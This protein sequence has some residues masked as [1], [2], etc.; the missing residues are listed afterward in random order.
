MTRWRGLDETAAKLWADGSKRRLTWP[1][2]LQRLDP[3]LGGLVVAVG[4]GLVS[5]GWGLAAV[6]RTRGFFDPPLVAPVPDPRILSDFRKADASFADAVMLGDDAFL[7][8][9]DGTIQR[10]DTETELFAGESLPRDGRLTGNLSLLSQGCGDALGAGLP[11]CPAGDT[12]FAVTDRGGLARRDGGGTW[13]VVLGDAGW[14]APDGTPV[15]QA[16][17]VAW[18][19]SED[20]RWML[21]AAGEKGLGLFDQ[22]GGGWATLSPTGDLARAP[23]RIVYAA[24]AFWLGGAAGL[25]RLVPSA[26]P[27]REAVAGGEGDIYDLDLDADGGLL[28]LRRG[29]CAE[30]CLSILSVSPRGVVSVLAGE[31]ALSPSLS[32][33]RVDHA[34]M[35]A[36]R[37]VVLG[38][39]GVHVYDPVRRN[40]QALETRPV[41][42][43]H[44]GKDGAVIHF[45]AANRMATVTNAT[46]REERVVSVPLT[47]ILPIT[48]GQVLGLNRDGA[49]LD[50]TPAVPVTLGFADPGLPT[51]VRFIAGADVAGTVVLLGP[52]G[53]LL[54][55]TVARRYA[56]Q[57]PVSLPPALIAARSIRLLAAGPRLWA[58][59]MASG[60][61]FLGVLDGDWPNRQV[62]F[63]PHVT[64]QSG[65]LSAQ[66]Q[67]DT[68]DL[69]TLSGAPFRIL[70]ANPDAAQP[71]TGAPL[72]RAIT[73]KTM[74][75]TG[76]DLIFADGSA[77]WTYDLAARGWEGPFDGPDGGVLDLALGQSLYALT[78]S[79]TLYKAG[80][81]SWEPV[82]GLGPGATLARRDVTDALAANGVVY[83]GGSGGV[84]AYAPD[85]RR[86][87]A[88]W[89][90]GRGDVRL[91]SVQGG[92]PVWLS[93][94]QLLFGEETIS[95]PEESVEGAWLGPDGP[96]YFAR[97]DGRLHAVDAGAGRT[98]LFRGSPAPGGDLIDA[99]NLPDG[100][101]FVLTSAAAAIYEPELRRWTRLSDEAGRADS[102]VEVMSGY[103]LRFDGDRFR[104][105]ALGDLPRQDSCAAGTLDVA[106]QTDISA[107][108]LAL[109]VAAGAVHVLMTN[110]EVLIWQAGVAQ[111]VLTPPNAA[112]ATA[113]LRRVYPGSNKVTFASNEALWQYDLTNRLWRSLP[114]RNGPS[115][116]ADVDILFGQDGAAATLW[117]TTGAGWG[118]DVSVDAATTGRADGLEFTRLSLPPMP[119]I[120]MPP[121]SLLDMAKNGS[122]LAV[123]GQQELALFD[124]DSMLSLG[125]IAL[126]Q[127]QQGWS[128]AQATGASQVVLVDGDLAAPLA[129]HMIDRQLVR[130]QIPLDEVSGRYAPGTDEDW[131]LTRDGGLWRIDADL[132]AYQCD[133]IGAIRCTV[134][135]PA[136]LEMTADSILA[137]ELADFAVNTEPA[138][139]PLGQQPEPVTGGYYLLQPDRLLSLDADFRLSK[140]VVGPAIRP[141]ARLFR[142]DTEVLLWEGPD[143][144]LWRIANRDAVLLL[145]RVLA[146]RTSDAGL[147]LTTPDGL[148]LRKG[149]VFEAPE[150]ALSVTLQDDVYSITAEGLIRDRRLTES[151]DPFLQF[152]VDTLAVHRGVLTINA[153]AQPGWWT[154]SVQG[155]VQF[156]WMSRCTP[157]LPPHMVGPGGIAIGDLN[158]DPREARESRSIIRLIETLTKPCQA[159]VPSTF[160][161][162]A[163]QRLLFVGGVPSAPVLATTTGEITLDANLAEVSRAPLRALLPDTQQALADLSDMKTRVAVMAGRSWLAP[164]VIEQRGIGRLQLTGPE[165][166]LVADGSA[167]LQP[168]DAFE[169]GWLGWDRATQRVRIGSGETAL[170][171]PPA[172]VIV[173]G[174]LLPAHVGR[175]AYLGN[176]HFAWLNEH[177]LWHVQ[178]GA[179]IEPVLM[180]T[181]PTVT[182]LAHGR[183]LLQGGGVDAVTGA[184]VADT[185]RFEAAVGPLT[186]S[187]RLR[188]GGVTAALVLAQQRV[189]A[190]AERGF[191]FDTRT[192]V[193]ASAGRAVLLTP[194]GLVPVSSL[195]GALPVPPG[196]DR[197][198]QEAAQLFAG[199]VG[200]WQVLA[201]D[202]TWQ[203]AA[204]PDSTRILAEESGRRWQRVVGRAEVV[205]IDVSDGW[206]VAGRGLDFAGDRLVAMAADTT[207]IVFVTGVGT[208]AAPGL[209]AAAP[210]TPALAP[211]PGV[212]TLDAL[213]TG[214]GPLVVWA[215]TASGRLEWDRAASRWIAPNPGRQPWESRMA[216]ISGPISISFAQGVAEATMQVTGLDGAL[217]DE[218][219][220]WARGEVLPFDRVR[221][222]HVE[223]GKLL[224]GTDFG[225]RRLTEASGLAS[226]DGLFAT[227]AGIP[228]PV[229]RVG[230]PDAAPAQ[231]LAQTANGGCLEMPTPDAILRTCADASGLA[232]RY[233][234]ESDFWRWTK[235]DGEVAGQY[236]LSDGSVLSVP[237]PLRGGL[238]HDRL[239]DRARCGGVEAELW[240]DGGVAT[241]LQGGIPV[242]LDTVAGL[243]AFHCQDIE[244]NLGQGQVLPTGLHG[245]GAN[246]VLAT[247]GGWQPEGAVQ[248]QSLLQRATGLLPWD[249][250]RLRIG[251]AGG[252]VV[253]EYRGLDDVWHPLDWAFGR[254]PV[255]TPLALS[256]A[257][258]GVQAFTSAGFVTLSRRSGFGAD[259][260]VL[261]LATPDDRNGF[262]NCLPDRVEMWDGSVQ[263]APELSAGTVGLRCADGRLFSGNPAGSVDR[264]AFAPMAE[265][266]FVER[267]V[268]DLPDFWTWTRKTAVPG[269]RGAL[270]IVFKEEQIGLNAGRLTIDDYIALAAPF[271]GFIE[272]VS[273]DGWWRQPDGDLDLQNAVRGPGNPGLV[274]GLASDRGP[275]NEGLLCLTGPT[276][277]IMPVSGPLRR[278]EACRDWTG[279]DQI[280]NWH[281]TESGPQASGVA[282][283]GPVMIRALE[284][285]RF[286]D[287]IVIGAPSALPRGAIVAPTQIGATVIGAQ[288]PEGIYARE[289]LGALTRSAT[290]TVLIVDANGMLSLGDN[291]ALFC[292]AVQDAAARLPEG[293][294]ILRIE[295]RDPQTA[296]ITVQAPEGRV[297][298]LLPCVD[299]ER[300][301]YWTDIRDVSD[302]ARFMAQAAGWPDMGGQLAVSLMSQGFNIGSGDTAGVTARIAI[303]GRPL[304]LF[305]GTNGRA[306][307][308]LTDQDFYGVDTDH[309]IRVVAQEAGDIA[310][311]NGPFVPDPPVAAPPVALSP[312]PTGPTLDAAPTLSSDL[313]SGPVPDPALAPQQSP[314]SSGAD[315]S[316]LRTLSTEDALAVQAALAALGIYAGDIDGAVGPMTRA[317]LRQWQT[318][319]G[320]PPTGALTETQFSALLAQGG[321]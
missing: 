103:L 46:L 70:A 225:L 19:V 233:V 282:L 195:Q 177:G 15:E 97:Q 88:D 184:V 29:G 247:V 132:V 237:L 131:A 118:A 127:A 289:K 55:D 253:A 146:I 163:D 291:G 241:R 3:V 166:A 259:P 138:S 222:V 8:R 154:V 137:V 38:E 71:L 252:A 240:A 258:G 286:K 234:M 25:E 145:P 94:Q 270:E 167:T 264:G 54:H 288:G 119:E 183:F 153:I 128:L 277:Q 208:H 187:E 74:A 164:P 317:A 284:A 92:A 60:Q 84:L 148:R 75:G 185:D 105:I 159:T 66:A 301:L 89:S 200:G 44:A 48:G 86:F 130:G 312:V 260:A 40:W 73:P 78:P 108:S 143:A 198:G 7:G 230:R 107:K 268:V 34:A 318:D 134:I 33:A 304:A 152:P 32:Q 100:R 321:P 227:G 275:D 308:L 90:G 175:M 16:D 211:D 95:A 14:V 202:G 236:M 266:A 178:N 173:G 125:R 77:I 245:I 170:R 274:T 302:R 124:S 136:P 250:S 155:R 229:R 193:G 116:V 315:T 228:D 299:V 305:P 281:Q 106:W 194:L 149:G 220:D 192:A 221:A 49:V 158:G 101:V 311:A 303:K 133:G 294:P 261:S 111:P 43:Y 1:R 209:R 112:P 287:L 99:R 214:A 300:S 319:S 98:C 269:Q 120:T 280:W 273:P 22:R 180:Q 160:Q 50:L 4:L 256:A 144:P 190:F 257:D 79:G 219:F 320:L 72:P 239:R 2:P 102:R 201:P 215:N 91:L 36:G 271:E 39:A 162:A 63:A 139:E 207:G 53:V 5:L 296:A 191:L 297:Q 172:Q 267:V 64:L 314:P 51:G 68:L 263:A 121:D 13:S 295:V 262:A 41:D 126:P 279:R 232:S 169:T 307:F 6:E 188:G 61:V 306:T 189:P 313:G 11:P 114:F 265:D 248:R 285:G 117:D 30:G 59:D 151:P 156:D 276:R 135:A 113:T 292:A 226:S 217:R 35:Q 182:G 224:L 93:G 110:G 81:Q 199:Q 141:G 82:S 23:V 62:V 129:L 27:E 56:F 26:N 231:L 243:T 45:S 255:D 83:L 171:L 18:A 28:A 179:S 10:Y 52:Q 246:P 204:A 242:R 310:P 104:A 150:A 213:G 168:W 235:T 17:L 244:A 115:A 12:L 31:T 69:V 309:A 21:A 249:A 42:A 123:L 76:Q 37:L 142:A 298:I 210:L 290:G 174:M 254:L 316:P 278:T 238:P 218:P 109:D 205:P 216:A 181:F 203:A 140:P 57:D 161:L 212:A 157:P 272:L 24:N 197:L 186:F 293:V 47:Q 9:T 283:N 96:V 67:G 87:I 196:T 176:N 58:I 122:V 65:L 165:R 223:A 80:E 206:R 251:L 147:A 20:G 85:K